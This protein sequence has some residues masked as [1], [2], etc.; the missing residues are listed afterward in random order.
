MVK[1]SSNI[2]MSI[3]RK[4]FLATS[5][6]K[7]PP[8]F[9]SS[10]CFST[11]TLIII[12]TYRCKFTN[13]FMNLIYL[14]YLLSPHVPEM[15]ALLWW[16]FLICLVT[17]VPQHLEQCAE[18]RKS[19]EVFVQWMKDLK[20]EVTASSRLAIFLTHVLSSQNTVGFAFFLVSTWLSLY[21]V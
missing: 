18:S 21:A 6:K 17:A 20:V 7:K 9:L 15:E 5:L 11:H 1:Y 4:T 2:E 13:L 3:L 19:S 14:I 8:H 12:V 10:P 16:E